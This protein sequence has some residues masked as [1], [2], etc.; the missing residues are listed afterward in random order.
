MSED[1]I[2]GR[3]I[4]GHINRRDGQKIGIFGVVRKH[5]VEEENTRCSRV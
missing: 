5:R 1:N 3:F 2:K 4:D